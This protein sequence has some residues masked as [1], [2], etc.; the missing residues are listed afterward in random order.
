MAQS[1]P[2]YATFSTVDL[3]K[4]FSGFLFWLIFILPLLGIILKNLH[5]HIEPAGLFDL[6]N[7]IALILFFITESVVEL[8]IIPIADNRRRD[9]FLDNS[10][11]SR[12]ALF[13]SVTYYDNDEVPVGLYKVAVNLFENCF[14][15]HSLVKKATRSK[16]L[17][18]AI[19]F[20][21]IIVF[22]FFGFQ[23]DAPM[24]MTVLQW[25][26]SSTLLGAVIKHLI[27]LARLSQIEQDWIALFGTS[28]FKTNPERY[29]PAI[30]KNW[31]NYETLH[32]RIPAEI[33]GKLY[34]QMNPQLTAD[35]TR[36][37][38]SFN[39]S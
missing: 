19:G 24:A 22:S 11:G 36:I 5:R 20:V 3:L 26:F 18:P 6:I 32:S 4:K 29:H 10:L 39:I 38:G 37:K 25:L 23:Q 16:I 33:P 15:T 13:P 27:L 31:L 21:V 28:D 1:A 14:F 9:D 30:Y 8:I 7:I 34:N 17:L 12:F 2:H 35:W